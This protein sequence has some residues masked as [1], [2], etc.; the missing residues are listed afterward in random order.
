M[1]GRLRDL[2]LDMEDRIYQGTLGSPKVRTRL[3]LRSTQPPSPLTRGRFS[4]QVK[5]RQVWR[6]ALEAGNYQLLSSS[7]RGV[8]R[9]TEHVHAQ[10]QPVQPRAGDRCT[11]AH[12][13]KVCKEN[14]SFQMCVQ[15]RE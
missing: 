8:G 5:D 2:L 12:T 13:P 14:S 15:A 7:S 4:G 3:P 11:H 10:P 9:Q 1:E 6:S